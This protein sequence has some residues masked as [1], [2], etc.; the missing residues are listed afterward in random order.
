MVIQIQCVL[1][2]IASGANAISVGEQTRLDLLAQGASAAGA[3]SSGRYTAQAVDYFKAE[4]A[5]AKASGQTTIN[6]NANTNA[7][8]QM[9]ATDVGWA[10]RTSSDVQYNVL[11]GMRAK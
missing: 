11:S 6:I 9:I 2:Q 1:S 7:S 5:K 10:I 4:L 8:S 3:A